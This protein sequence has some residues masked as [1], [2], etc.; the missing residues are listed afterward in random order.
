MSFFKRIFLLIF[1]LL[2]CVACQSHKNSPSPLLQKN[3]IQEIHIQ[4]PFQNL[5]IFRENDSYKGRFLPL[6]DQNPTQENTF[7]AFPFDKDNVETLIDV[8]LQL[9]A[10]QK[11][12]ASLEKNSV[13]IN[14]KTSQGN[15]EWMISK[16]D[17]LRRIVLKPSTDWRTKQIL[18][19]NVSHL[20]QIKLLNA[21]EPISL[22]RNEDMQWIW[23]EKPSLQINQEWVESLARKLSHLK[24]MSLGENISQKDAGLLEPIS[25]LEINFRGQEKPFRVLLGKQKGQDLYYAEIEGLPDWKGEIFTVNQESAEKLMSKPAQIIRS[26]K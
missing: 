13:K 3:D 6:K 8:F 15:Q 10:T 17:P 23:K 12:N 2:C 4:S 9:T 22:E 1:I 24:A 26:N 7:K 20:I 19:E 25:A 16:D 18:N 21:S 14:F 11:P 5:K